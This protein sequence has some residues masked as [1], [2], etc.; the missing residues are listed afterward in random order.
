MYKY[1]SN[2][3]WRKNQEYWSVH[4]VVYLDLFQINCNWLN[5]A[6]ICLYIMVDFIF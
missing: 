4:I 2:D 3:W 6:I 1:I 5:I